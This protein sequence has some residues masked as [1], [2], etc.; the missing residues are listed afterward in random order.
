MFRAYSF[1]ESELRRYGSILNLVPPISEENLLCIH[2][3]MFSATIQELL[4]NTVKARGGAMLVIFDDEKPV[5][6]SRPT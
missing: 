4:E 3:R 6:W 2:G 5:S 1:A